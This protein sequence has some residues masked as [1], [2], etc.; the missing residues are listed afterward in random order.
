MNDSTDK[1]RFAVDRG[2]TFT[3]VIGVDPEGNYHILKLLSNSSDYEDASIEGI[4]RLLGL[5]RDEHLPENM[6][7]GP[8]CYGFGGPLTITDA[9]LL[10]GRIIVDYFPK[11]S[12]SDRRSSLDIDIVKK[13]FKELTKE[14]NN[15]TCY[16]MSPEDVALGFIN[17]ANQIMAMAIKEISVS[18][19]FDVRDYALVCFGGAGGQHAC[20]IASLLEI[21]K[22]ILH[23]LASVLSAYG[24]GLSNP[25]KRYSKTLLRIF[26]RET[27]EELL[28]IFREV[29]KRIFSSE[30]LNASDCTVI[31]SIDLRHKGTETFLTVLYEDY[32]KIL[33][34]FKERYLRHFGFYP[35]DIPLEVVNLRVEIQKRKR[36]LPPFQNKHKESIENSEAPCSK[37]QS[38]L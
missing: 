20:G 10:T 14:I 25:E 24:V 23:P 30:R 31:R 37:M 2:G 36:F 15:A 12:G 1:W 29:E 28:D 4:R 32:D 18:R 13:A 34:S 26:N 35:A 6:I 9:N 5:P 27:H 19:G 3:D 17:I 7:E 33:G 11:T 22:I 21:D 16:N 8:A 38:F